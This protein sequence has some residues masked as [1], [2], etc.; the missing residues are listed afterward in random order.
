M[1]TLDT[2]TT[3]AGTS[4]LACEPWTP[5]EIYAVAA[6]WSEASAPVYSYTSCGW[7]STAY[8]VADY[9]HDPQAALEDEIR[10][11]LRASTAEDPDPAEVAAIV[12]D[13]VEI[14]PE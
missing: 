9:S 3:P 10:L 4:G 7:H 13:A 11:A 12:S 5:G 8:Q 2:I 1:T 14:G 6:N